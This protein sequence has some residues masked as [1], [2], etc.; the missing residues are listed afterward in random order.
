MDF[1]TSVGQTT[2]GVRVSALIIRD[3]CLLT[4]RS[5]THSL[6]I[7]GAIQVGEA[8]ENAIRREVM[9]EL[10]VTCT[11]GA[12]AFV[13]ENQFTEPPFLYHTIEL[14]YFVDITGD[15]PERILDDED[16]VVE[17]LPV[18]QLGAY[19]VRPHF[20]VEELPRWNGIIKHIKQE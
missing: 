1:R 15:V 2:F 4:A 8:T 13:V 7:G 19:D 6:L 11:V 10:G 17:W 5:G 12:L 16:F 9:E 3:G 20:L 14:H 18:D